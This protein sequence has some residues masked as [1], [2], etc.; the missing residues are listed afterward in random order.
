MEE[1]VMTVSPTLQKYLD[2][3]VTYDLIPHVPTMSSTRTAEACHVPGDALA[4]AVVLRRDG[5][6]R[7]SRHADPHGGTAIRAA[8]GEGLARPLQHARLR[9]LVRPTASAWSSD[10]KQNAPHPFAVEQVRAVSD[11][12][13]ATGRRFSDGPQRSSRSRTPDRLT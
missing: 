11:D 5:G 6:R 3:S 4:K 9:P 10:F 8:D 7:R 12:S 2:Q 13:I 1:I